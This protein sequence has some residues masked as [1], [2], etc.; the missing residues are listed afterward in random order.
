VSLLL[1]WRGQIN[2][3]H[4]FALILVAGLG[5]EYALFLSRRE[6]DHTD[7]RANRTGVFICAASTISVFAI[8]SQSTYTVLASIGETVAL[9]AAL[10][11][12]Y[13]R[14]FATQEPPPSRAETEE[15]Q[16]A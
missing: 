11:Y 9:G 1:L 3:F 12:L 8:I 10:S 5:A 13:A 14:V 16:P 6:A 2:L 7:H 4:L 15:P